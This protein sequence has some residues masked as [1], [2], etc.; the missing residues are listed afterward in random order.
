MNPVAIDIDGVL[1]TDTFSPVL[2][3]LAA[4]A[5]LPYDA[6]LENTVFSENRARAAAWMSARLGAAW[7]PE[8]VLERFFA[9]RQQRLTT[10]PVAWRPGAQDLIR[11]LQDQGRRLVCYGG[12]GTAHFE[13]H[14][15]PWTQAFETYVCTDAI[16]PGL[17][18]I[19]G[20]VLGLPPAQVWFLDDTLRAGLAARTLGAGFIGCP[21]AWPWGFQASGMHQARLPWIVQDLSEITPG[22]LREQ[23]ARLEAGRFYG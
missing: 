23:E 17:A 15:G 8:R 21:A 6:E 2:K 19:C 9:L 18:E 22:F 16:R 20:Q 13:A 4:E 7:P 10:E 1:L 12:L 14:L 3:D 11:R 5:G